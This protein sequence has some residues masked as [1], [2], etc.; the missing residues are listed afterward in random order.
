MERKEKDLIGVGVGE[1]GKRGHSSLPLTSAIFRSPGFVRMSF[2]GN[3]SCRL[4]R[5]PT[6]AQALPPKTQK[7]DCSI[8]SCPTL[9]DPPGVLHLSLSMPSDP[10]RKARVT[11][12]NKIRC[13]RQQIHSTVF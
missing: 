9:Y 6:V 3:L 10:L 2:L 1:E 11:E 8:L 7:D 4:P 5:N 13:A 12:D